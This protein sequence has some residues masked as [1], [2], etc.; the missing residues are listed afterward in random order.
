MARTES[1]TPPTRDRAIDGLRALAICGVL[2]GHWFV[3]ALRVGDD[4]ALHVTSPLANLPQLAPASW[5]LQM[6]GLFFLVGGY[7]SARSRRRSVERG[8]TYRSWAATRLLRLVRPVIAATAVLGA[9]LPLLA[10]A[11]V[12]D[13]TLRTAAVLVVQPLWFLGVYAVLTALTPLALA[14]DRR[15]GAWAAAPA[16][17]VVAGVDLLRYGPWADAMP[18]WL[19]LL[20]IVPGWAFGYL[21]GVSWA[22]GRI[23]RRGAALL[24][25]GGAVAS[26][27]LVARFGYPLSMVGVPGAD[28]GNSHP[29]SLLVLTLAA[30]QCGLA[31]VLHDR[32]AALLRRPALWTGV[33]MI[34]LAA[35]TIF[36]WHQIALLT[37]SG[38]MLAL[39]PGG[40]PGLH[41]VPMD[42]GWVAC[43]AGWLLAQLVLLGCLVA[44]ARR[45]ESPWTGMSLPARATAI[46]LATV[47]ATYA[48][49]VM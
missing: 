38:G 21:L 11:G 43:R 19:A 31:I 28:R 40:V 39:V 44:V 30:A 17:G 8:E 4:G 33:A 13:G 18:G 3:M 6:L 24:A 47:F 41:G 45:F 1:A 29:P 15:L 14:L 35:L 7:S 12:P 36:C 26:V 20:N 16:L 42:L 2:L 5:V 25:I 48:A 37:L 27:L 10:V 49:V 9:A 32:I 34:N 23:T 22:H 46:T